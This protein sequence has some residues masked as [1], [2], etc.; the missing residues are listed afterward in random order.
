MTALKDYA[1]L[2][3]LGAE[4]AER[5]AKKTAT[6]VDDDEQ[7]SRLYDLHWALRE[8]INRIAADTLE[9]LRAKARAADSRSSGMGRSRTTATEASSVCAARSMQTCSPCQ[10]MLVLDLDDLLSA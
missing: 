5:E 6:P 4:L 9:G 1:V 3:A 10:P 8:R 2:I 7:Y